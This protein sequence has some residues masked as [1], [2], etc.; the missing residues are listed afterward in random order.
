M[1][2]DDI[3]IDHL[4]AVVHDLQ[5]RHILAVGLQGEG[6]AWKNQ[7]AAVIIMFPLSTEH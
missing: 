4:E 1:N 6:M 3:L 7:S 5:I 2:A